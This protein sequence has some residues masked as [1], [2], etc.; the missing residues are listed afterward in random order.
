MSLNCCLFPRPQ[1]DG[2][3]R[4]RALFV[5]EGVD[6]TSYEEYAEIS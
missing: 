3:Q 2:C 6:R 5:S 4:G 1:L